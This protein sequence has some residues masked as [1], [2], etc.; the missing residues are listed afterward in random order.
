MVTSHAAGVAVGVDV[1]GTKLATALVAGDGTVLDAARF[2]TPETSAAA[3][4]DVIVSSVDDF[5]TR[6][7]LGAVPVGVGAA[8]L[9]DRQGVVRYS[10]NLP[11]SEFPLQRELAARVSGPVTVDNDANVAAYA[12]YRSGAG[13]PARSSMIM[14]TLGTGVGGG[15]I[16]GNRLVRGAGGMAGE[17]GHIAVC[18]GGPL[19][20]CGARGCLE[21]VASGTAIAR[22]AQEALAQ[23]TIPAGSALADLRPEE[24]TGKEVTIAAHAGDATA[25]GILATA[26]RWLGV[27][28]AS[29]IAAFDP[30]VVVVGGG[31]MQAGELVLG[32]ARESA[33]DRLLGRGHRELAPILPASLGDHAGVVGAALLA[34]D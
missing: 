32:P 11:W 6:H 12:E 19:C 23:G 8:G 20:P 31:A 1:G 17:L 26:G 15:I 7:H 22:F 27:G 16:L 5:T 9:I 30:E 29:L 10:P 3:I 14:L 18:E 28:I 4:L 13:S 34:L 21:A 25:I 2:A 33:Q 24:I